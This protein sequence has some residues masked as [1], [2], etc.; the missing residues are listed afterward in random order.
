MMSHLPEAGALARIWPPMR[1]PD[2]RR[3][4]RDCR[5]RGNFNPGLS[6]ACSKPQKNA[7][8]LRNSCE[9][10]H[11]NVDFR[12]CNRRLAYDMR[13]ALAA[14]RFGPLAVFCVLTSD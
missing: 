1:S 9:F 5:R 10:L 8:F 13:R 4:S 3:Q 11:E 7:R 2:A 6:I 12:A 14:R